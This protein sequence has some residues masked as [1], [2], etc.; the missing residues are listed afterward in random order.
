MGCAS[1][2]HCESFFFGIDIHLGLK[3]NNDVCS[4]SE[5]CICILSLLNGCTNE[6]P[7]KNG[8]D[9]HNH[10]RNI[11]DPRPFVLRNRSLL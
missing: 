9:A 10:E 1:L 3:F 2:E 6:Q 4:A 5:Y 8:Q 11:S 7:Q